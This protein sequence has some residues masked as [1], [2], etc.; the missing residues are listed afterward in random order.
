MKITFLILTLGFFVL[1]GCRTPTAFVSERE[2]DK[3]ALS[4]KTTEDLITYMEFDEKSSF[5]YDFEYDNE[6]LYLNIATK[7]LALKRKIVNFGFTVWI[8]REGGKERE[9]GFRHPV[10]VATPAEFREKMRRHEPKEGHLL[11]DLRPAL[12]RADEIEL[13][14]I[15]GES[16]RKVKLRDTRIRIKTEIV[17]G[18]LFYEA[19]I[20]FDVLE[21]EYDPVS[22]KASIGI[23]LETGYLE[24][25][26]DP[27][28]EMPPGAEPG[29]RTRPPRGMPGGAP[30]QMPHPDL[31]RER[32]EEIEELRKPTELWIKLKFPS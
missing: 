21:I 10:G 19:K 6:N 1:S 16:V 24:Q 3:M 4:K 14:G 8:D 32:S 7:D 22:E 27:D 13:I 26:S 23:G 9:Q 20:P 31:L 15:Y 12:E 11:G 18:V 2:P 30:R 5:Y 17:E 29:G 25:P 28:R